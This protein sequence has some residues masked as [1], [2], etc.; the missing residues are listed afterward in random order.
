MDNIWLKIL[1]EIIGIQEFNFITRIIYAS[2][3][4]NSN[5]KSY[6]IGNDFISVNFKVTIKTYFN[7]YSF[8]GS[9]KVDRV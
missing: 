4:G 6:E 7:C 3:G 8:D 2:R 9:Y 1:K 5:S